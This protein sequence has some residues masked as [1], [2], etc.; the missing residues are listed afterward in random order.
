MM[1]LARFDA[2]YHFRWDLIRVNFRNNVTSYDHNIQK[3]KTSY[4]KI[5]FTYEQAN[6]NREVI[7]SNNLLRYQYHS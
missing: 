4:D 5:H 3:G 6:H 1:L 7:E 2:A